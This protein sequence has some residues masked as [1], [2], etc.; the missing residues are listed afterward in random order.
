MAEK[1]EKYL[2]D[3]SKECVVMNQP[4]FDTIKQVYA[5]GRADMQ[6]EC[7]EAIRTERGRWRNGIELIIFTKI[8]ATIESA[9]EIRA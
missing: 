1:L 5:A 4:I 9:A 8:I 7:V 3:M 6:R 2:L